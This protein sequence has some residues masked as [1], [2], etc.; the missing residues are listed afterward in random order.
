LL[1]LAHREE[2]ARTAQFLIEL[3]E[4]WP[5]AAESLS[6]SVGPLDPSDAK[7]LCLSLHGSD[8]PSAQATAEVIAHE[9]EGSPFLIEEL[10]R[11]STHDLVTADAT[12]TL[13]AVVAGRLVE[14]PES[15]RRVVEMVAVGGRPLP[16]LDTRG[17]RAR[18]VD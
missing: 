13:E 14:L 2:D 3:E 18:R 12:V 10:V 9:S 11:S 16:R 6:L 15:A 17:G 7:R 1:V 5:G 4:R 8:D